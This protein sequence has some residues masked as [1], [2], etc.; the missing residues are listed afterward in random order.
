VLLSPKKRAAAK[1]EVVFY[2]GLPLFRLRMNRLPIAEQNISRR[3]SFG[4]CG[5]LFVAGHSVNTL[6]VMLNKSCM[7]PSM[8]RNM[9]C[10]STGKGLSDGMQA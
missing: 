10:C 5:V 8:K 7:M 3:G 9:M 4:V 2:F 6:S 1:K